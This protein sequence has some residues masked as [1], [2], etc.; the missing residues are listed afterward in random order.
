VEKF[1]EKIDTQCKAKF[2]VIK[3]SVSHCDQSAWETVVFLA[4]ADPW[5][6]S[7]FY[8]YISDRMLINSHLTSRFNG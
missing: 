1:I 5:N 4:Y 6:D 8:G 7:P 3:V 2:P